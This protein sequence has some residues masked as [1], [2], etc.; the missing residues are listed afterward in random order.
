MSPCEYLPSEDP[1]DESIQKITLSTQLA[2]DTKTYEISLPEWC[3]DFKDV[4][5]KKTYDVLPPHHPYD[6]TIDLKLS[7]VQKSPRSTL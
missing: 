7:F 4:F 1:V 3:K 5:S 2:Q 6:H